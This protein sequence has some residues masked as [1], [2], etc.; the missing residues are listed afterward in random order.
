M[1]S[2]TAQVSNPSHRDTI[3]PTPARILFD[4]GSYRTYVTA[5]FA[6]K[7]QL[8]P[9]SE[10]TLSISTFGSN[11]IQEMTAATADLAVQFLNGRRHIITATIVP[12]ITGKVSSTTLPPHV[13]Q[14]VPPGLQL[15]DEYSSCAGS[16]TIDILL[17]NDYYNDFVKPH[18]RQLAPGLYLLDTHLGWMISGRLTLTSA[19]AH[20][21]TDAPATTDP[22]L[23]IV[24]ST[25]STDA[26]ALDQYW[27][28]ET[29]GISDSPYDSDDAA[30][31]SLFDKSIAH[32]D[33][34]Y[35][36]GWP[37]KPDHDLPDNYQL[38]KGRL[39]SLLRRLRRD[40]DTLEKYDE[41][42]QKQLKAGIIEVVPQDTD[43]TKCHY[44]PH[45]SVS[46][47]GSATTKLR[48]VYDGSAKT[49][50]ANSSLNDCLYRGPVLL[51]D[52]AGI[53]LRFRLQRVAI[54]ADIE[55]A[56]L[57]IGLHLPDRDVTRFLWLKD[58]TTPT[59]H[60]E[61]LQEFRFTRVPFGVVCS[62][63]LL[64]A[65]V[66]HHLQA[67][68]DAI[69]TQ[70]QRD[71][72]VDNLITGTDSAADAVD[73][74]RKAKT[75]FKS[76]HM[77]LRSW[78]SNSE[79][80]LEQVPQEDRDE[81]TGFKV[82]GLRWHRVDD[83]LAV[84][85]PDSASLQ[86][87]TTNRA[88]LHCVAAVYDPLGLLSPVTIPAKILLQDLWQAKVGW[89]DALPQPYLERWTELLKDLLEIAQLSLPRYIGPPTD[90]ECTYTL[91]CF[92]DASGK[93]YAAAVYLHTTWSSGSSTHLVFS[94]TRLAPTKPIA[95]FPDMVPTTS[96]FPHHVIVGALSRH[97]PLNFRLRFVFR[98]NHVSAVFHSCRA[99]SKRWNLQLNEQGTAKFRRLPWTKL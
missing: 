56:F 15:A 77:N 53:L 25:S 78:S 94:K 90:D 14:N 64:A 62:P 48:I 83:T 87:A 63:F 42:I 31:Q 6:D 73:L 79:A 69:T 8:K 18:R 54:T 61:N 11:N 96:V 33:G 3:A 36:V 84:P 65:T 24:P 74:Y 92:C 75:T 76:A 86:A 98:M 68:D 81:R 57:Q 52:L 9:T 67:T 29:I 91:L 41:V 21:S 17:G 55:K 58:A 88:I 30:A 50:A 34:R 47:P 22:S 44:L 16:S 12:T 71:L 35:E 97:P 60:A 70:L 82:L 5:E 19:D 28:M 85:A 2:A 51:Q 95:P 13:L 10:E 45:H 66:Q 4:T 40:P 59:A 46:S 38:A 72:Y 49:N 26:P 80:F 99:L 23:L 7:L 39:T 93:A 89:D 20:L 1:Q 32:T 27:R 43:S 37:W